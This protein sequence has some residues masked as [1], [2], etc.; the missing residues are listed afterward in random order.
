MARRLPHPSAK[1]LS[2]CEL[3]YGPGDR[4]L[5]A[6]LL[7][8]IGFRVLDPRKDPIPGNLG[9]AADPYLIVYLDPK[10]DDVFDNV[11]YCS[12][13]CGEQQ[14][15]ESALRARMAQDAELA[16]LHRELC[17]AFVKLPQ[18]MTHIGVGYASP[19]EVEEAL[20]RVAAEPALRG[21]VRTTKVYRPGEEGS[22]DERVVQGFVYTD[23]LS[24]GLLCAGQQIELQYQV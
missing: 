5:A 22:L 15:F 16:G 6:T 14:R 9:P 13:A 19:R 24:T 7:R 11:L 2:H 17:D 1:L 20:A 23:V 21:R 18:G 3:V 4:E 8:A 12:E 10:G